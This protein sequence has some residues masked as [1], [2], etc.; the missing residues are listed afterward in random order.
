M[1]NERIIFKKKLSRALIK[2][3]NEQK[4]SRKKLSEDLN[5]TYTTICDYVKGRT[6]PNMLLLDQ[7]LK[8]LNV[9]KEEVLEEDAI[10][11]STK[12]RFLKKE[13]YKKSNKIKVNDEEYI[14][15]EIIERI[16]KY[17]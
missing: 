16:L 15:L 12:I 17:E 10:N 2:A 1:K 9:S 3:L 8:Y 7:I 4:I 5:V 6:T 13:L 14:K 11:D